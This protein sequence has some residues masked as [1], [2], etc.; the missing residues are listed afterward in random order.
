MR[1]YPC[2]KLFGMVGKCAY[3]EWTGYWKKVIFILTNFEKNLVYLGLEIL[4]E[5][6]ELCTE[7]SFL[8]KMLSTQI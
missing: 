7:P 4:C 5:Y 8:F 1:R 2:A 6:F 3:A